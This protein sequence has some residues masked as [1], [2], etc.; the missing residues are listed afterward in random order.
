MA[1]T[2]CHIS[3][4]YFAW[5]TAIA[6]QFTATVISYIPRSSPLEQFWGFEN[7]NF[8]SNYFILHKL[9]VD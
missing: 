8:A 4:K 3:L 9:L 7:I 6:D 2:I 5:D 1:T